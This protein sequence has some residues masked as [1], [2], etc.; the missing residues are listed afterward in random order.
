VRV[1]LVGFFIM[2]LGMERAKRTPTGREMAK[3]IEAAM[4]QELFDDEAIA[5]VM[6]ALFAEKRLK[7]LALLDYA[8]HDDERV[9]K[10]VEALREDEKTLSGIPGVPDDDDVS[11]LP[12]KASPS[13]EPPRPAAA[14]PATPGARPRK[15]SSGGDPSANAP[16]ARAFP[17]PAL[18]RM[19]PETS[20]GRAKSLSVL[21]E[22]DSPTQVGPVPGMSPSARPATAEPEARESRRPPKMGVFTLGPSEPKASAAPSSREEDSGISEVSEVSR[23]SRTLVGLNG[24]PR[25]GL[26]IVAAMVLVG[27]VVLFLPDSVKSQIAALLSQPQPQGTPAPA[28]A[29]PEPSTAKPSQD[30]YEPPPPAEAGEKPSTSTEAATPKKPGPSATSIHTAKKPAEAVAKPSEET[31]DTAEDS[32]E[33]AGTAHA[34][35]ARPAKAPASQGKPEGRAPKEPVE[36]APEPAEP[37]VGPA[38]VDP[39]IKPME[40]TPPSTPE[41][42]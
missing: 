5:E 12:M 40:L 41:P 34:P 4:G 25:R 27:L 6:Q 20:S 36:E 17:A 37:S 22:E 3:A 38:E 21:E 16:K 14:R 30:A 18:P 28:T 2:A 23:V 19:L 13:P 32:S 33:E 35:P 1:A 42:Q 7:T 10:V 15:Q 26:W 9:S 29:P 8:S 39:S 31:S 24:R 11:T